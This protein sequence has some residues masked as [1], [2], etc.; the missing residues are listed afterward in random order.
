[1]SMWKCGNSHRRHLQGEAGAQEAQNS[2]EIGDFEPLTGKP[3]LMLRTRFAT[4]E[5]LQRLCEQVMKLVAETR[6][7][8]S[9]PSTVAEQF[10]Q[11][12]GS[13]KAVARRRRR[14]GGDGTI[15]GKNVEGMR[16]NL[17]EI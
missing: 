16:T 15:P 1:M 14:S 6:L 12:V 10:D 3:K 8:L 9:A 4:A 5:S 11:T 13:C 2:G 7:E 17:T